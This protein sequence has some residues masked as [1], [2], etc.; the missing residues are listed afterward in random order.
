MTRS[1]DGWDLM[2]YYL[3]LLCMS[4]ILYRIGRRGD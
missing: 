2:N 1:N 3:S 4:C